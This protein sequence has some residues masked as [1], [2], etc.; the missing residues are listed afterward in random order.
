[1]FERELDFFV[2]HQDELV[3]RYPGKVLVIR[4]DELAGVFENA[5]EAY[6]SAQRQFEPG[7]YMIQ[8]CEAG[9]GAYTVTIAL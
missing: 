7:T 6:L 3:A 8:P 4:G 1:M 5:L 2:K 9:S